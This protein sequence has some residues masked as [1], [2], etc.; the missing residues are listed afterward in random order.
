M[1]TEPVT[2]CAF[3]DSIL[4]QVQGNQEILRLVSFQ[5]RKNSEPPCLILSES[6]KTQ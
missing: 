5:G 3:K 6:T 1:I 4:A 2:P